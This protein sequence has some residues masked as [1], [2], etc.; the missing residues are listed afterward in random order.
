MNRK[1]FLKVYG[2]STEKWA[3]RWDLEIYIRPCSKCNEDCSMTIPFAYGQ[4]RGLMADVCKCGNERTPFCLVRDPKHGDLF[5]GN[6][7][8][9]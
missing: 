2:I 6:G 7:K 3:E 1:K 9:R 4:M 8:I 5:G